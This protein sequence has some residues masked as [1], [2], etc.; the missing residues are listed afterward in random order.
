MLPPFEQQLISLGLLGLGLYSS[1]GPP[2]GRPSFH[3]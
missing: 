2:P 1:P 3:G